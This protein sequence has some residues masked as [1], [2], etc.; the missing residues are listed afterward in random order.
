VSANGDAFQRYCGQHRCSVQHHVQLPGHRSHPHLSGHQFEQFVLVQCSLV[1]Y[2]VAASV[3]LRCGLCAL[4]IVS[5][6]RR[7]KFSGTALVVATSQE[8][9]DTP[10]VVNLGQTLPQWT[11]ASTV[12]SSVGNLP[13]VFFMRI[14]HHFNRTA[15]PSAGLVAVSNPN[16][17]SLSPL[18][19]PNA[20]LPYTPGSVMQ[21]SVEFGCSN[22]EDG[23]AVTVTLLTSPFAPSTFQFFKQCR[24]CSE[25][26]MAGLGIDRCSVASFAV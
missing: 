14:S 15:Q 9:L 21:L 22:S 11:Q 12:Y 24:T 8:L 5:G 3:A 26:N 13:G 19:T 16:Y 10:D 7:N 6:A 17:L 4:S 25:V 23:G 2:R 18:L 1:R 20:S